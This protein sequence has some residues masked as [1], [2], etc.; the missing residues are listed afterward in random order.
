M[1]PPRTMRLA[2]RAL[3]IAIHDAFTMDAGPTRLRRL[4][5]RLRT[6]LNI[7]IFDFALDEAEMRQL[8]RLATGER[9]GPGPDTFN[10]F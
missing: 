9:I 7:D 5:A 10:A 2:D 3:M 1:A 4:L 6:R 8:N